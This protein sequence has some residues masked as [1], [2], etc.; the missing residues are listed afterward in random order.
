MSGFAMPNEGFAIGAYGT[1]LKT[2]DGGRTWSE[3]IFEPRPAPNAKA[4]SATPG[5]PPAA[6]KQNVY[7][8]ESSPGDVHLN[9]VASSSDGKLYLAAEAGHIFRS[10]DGGTSWLELP[11]PY[12]GSFFGVLPLDP[13][14]LL[15]FGLRGH[16]FRSDD[17]GASWRALETGTTAM[18]T[19]ALRL[20]A[21][22]IVIT[23]LSGTLLVSRDG[24]QS[25]ALQTQ[26]DRAG[27][28]VALAAGDKLLT[29]GEGGIKLIALQSAA[30]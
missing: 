18:L 30:Q 21:Q 12:E 11:S 22:T 16:L 26:A 24:G 3:Q 5:A 20:D 14:A 23:G 19:N 27:R 10:D 9:A 13:P 6:G 7:A 15:A 25:F 1:I 28:T 2:S 8:V 17:A 29:A 4:E